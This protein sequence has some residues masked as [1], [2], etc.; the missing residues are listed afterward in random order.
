MALE[1]GDAEDLEL[2]RLASGRSGG[3]AEKI[4]STCPPITSF[5]AGALP[6]YETCVSWTSAI[7]LKRTAARCSVVPFPEEA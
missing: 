2:A 7:S 1:R 4:M 3:S 5:S 6:L